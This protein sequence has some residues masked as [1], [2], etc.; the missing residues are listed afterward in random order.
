MPS[1][2]PAQAAAPAIQE[3]EADQVLQLGHGVADGGLGA[4]QAPGAGGEAA[5]LGERVEG[6]QLGEVE[7][8]VHDYESYS[9]LM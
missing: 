6:P 5:H 4:A 9:C 1:H 7:Q 2:A 3:G 8:G